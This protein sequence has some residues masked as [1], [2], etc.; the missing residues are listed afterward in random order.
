MI[1][2]A[3]ALG[4]SPEKYSKTRHN[5]GQI[6]LRH[7]AKELGKSFS[8]NKFCSANITR[9][10]VGNNE[11]ILADML[12]YMN[13]SGVNLKKVLKFFKLNISEVAIFYDDIT[14][15]LGRLK[16]TERASSG[17]HN[18]L[19]DIISQFGTD[20][21][22]YRVGIGA[23]PFKTMPLS[24]YV[25][26]KLSDIEIEQLQSLTGQVAKSFELMFTKGIAFAQNLINQKK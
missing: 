17:G 15:D 26:S 18:G 25:L 6:V 13:E 16:I 5:A 10:Q 11:L 1:R 2:L 7:W 19:A 14:M 21:L 8:Y 22:R 9:V 20:F 3:V 23:K 24:D 4:N 12:G